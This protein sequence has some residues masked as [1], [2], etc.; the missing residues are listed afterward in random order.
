MIVEIFQM[1]SKMQ[2]VN[3]T[4]TI[5]SILKLKETPIH[6]TDPIQNVTF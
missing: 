4:P 5:E 3:S 2:I 1:E 6:T